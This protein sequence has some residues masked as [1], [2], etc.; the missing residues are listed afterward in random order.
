MNKLT[1]SI[2]R[3][4]GLEASMS[5]LKT[6][7]VHLFNYFTFNSNQILQSLLSRCGTSSTSVEK[8]QKKLDE[9]KVRLKQRNQMEK[10]EQ[11]QHSFSV[12]MSVFFVETN[13]H[14]KELA[15][16]WSK[17]LDLN[18]KRMS[19]YD[20]KCWNG[21]GVVWNR[22]IQSKKPNASID[23]S[24]LSDSTFTRHLESLKSLNAKLIKHL[25]KLVILGKQ[26]T[27]SDNVP[28]ELEKTTVRSE[29]KN[30][31][32]YTVSI[33]LPKLVNKINKN[34]RDNLDEYYETETSSMKETNDYGDDEDDLLNYENGDY[35][36]EDTVKPETADEDDYEET[37][38]LNSERNGNDEDEDYS[39]KDDYDYAF[40]Y[41]DFTTRKAQMRIASNQ[42]LDNNKEVEEGGLVESGI[43]DDMDVDDDEEDDDEEDDG[44]NEGDQKKS[45]NEAKRNSLI[46][47]YMSLFPS[48]SSSASFSILEIKSCLFFLLFEHF[49][50]DLFFFG[51]N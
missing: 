14:F 50:F 3:S 29:S 2:D 13:N 16:F 51:L 23:S 44:D 25:D 40:N 45:L 34:D 43:S 18:C 9:K 30:V 5:Q 36:N 49:V 11:Q 24:D 22:I 32:T 6:K 41:E 1:F 20:D 26:T 35:E 31:L 42:K 27:Y 19:S 47:V 39:V 21:S 12:K 38:D 17:L 33:E 10:R 48:L 46:D 7:L 37:D 15:L 8:L 4:T 28:H